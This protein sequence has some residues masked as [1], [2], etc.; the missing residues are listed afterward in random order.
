MDD[1]ELDWTFGT[2]FDF[3][4][5]RMLSFAFSSATKP[6][7][8][9]AQTFDALQPGGFLE[10][11]DISLSFR[12]N[13]GSIG[14]EMKRWSNMLRRVAWKSGRDWNCSAKY[15]KLLVEAG[16]E[17]VNEIMLEWPINN[18]T[19]MGMWGRTNLLGCLE[20]ISMAPMTRYLGFSK[21][22]V[23]EIVERVK[24]EINQK[25]LEASIPV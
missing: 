4:H 17:D 18:K 24:K 2:K 15:R 22:E 8:V 7:D 19:E 25:G 10:L 5:G 14:T 13:D 23:M 20:P 21:E 11:Q 6:A 16:Y 9:I 3:I 12:T 1:F